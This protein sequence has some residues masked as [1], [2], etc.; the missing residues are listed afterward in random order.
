MRA[1]L[2]PLLHVE[3]GGTAVLDFRI[4][5]AGTKETVTVSGAPPLVDH[6][7]APSQP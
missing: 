1:Q 5:L 7:Q 6:Y 3:V 2:S 4:A